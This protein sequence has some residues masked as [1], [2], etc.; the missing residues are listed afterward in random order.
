M[1]HQVYPQGQQVDTKLPC[2][3]VSV[4]E[5]FMKWKIVAWAKTYS[6]AHKRKPQR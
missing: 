1:Y 5:R 2:G 4:Q 6:H 3:H